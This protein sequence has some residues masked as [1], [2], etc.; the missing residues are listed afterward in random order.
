MAHPDLDR[1]LEYCVPFAQQQLKKRGEFY[2]FAVQILAEGELNPVAI[3]DGVETP[4]P[5]EM[6]TAFID[7]FRHFAPQ[8][9]LEAVAICYDGRVTVPGKEKQDAITVFLEHSNGECVTVYI[10]YIKKILR[11]YQYEDV[12]GSK[13]ERR[14]FV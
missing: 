10:P 2:P 13:A 11:G 14:V 3:D 6:I 4:V 1:L 7:L 9:A 12:I 8:S 5:S